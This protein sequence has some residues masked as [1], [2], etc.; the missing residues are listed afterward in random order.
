[1]PNLDASGTPYD[2][3]ETSASDGNDGL[4]ALIVVVVVLILVL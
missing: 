4:I 2:Y 3:G 1:M